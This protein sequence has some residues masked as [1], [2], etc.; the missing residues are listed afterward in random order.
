VLGEIFVR[1]LNDSERCCGGTY[2]YDHD[3]VL[4]DGR[5]GTIRGKSSN[6]GFGGTAVVCFG[7]GP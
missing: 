3:A 2:A 6:S 5:F 7:T 1:W 4:N